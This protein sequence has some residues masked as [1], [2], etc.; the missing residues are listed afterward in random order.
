MFLSVCI[1]YVQTIS[2]WL[3]KMGKNR[4]HYLF[5]TSKM[6]SW[7]TTSSP[8]EAWTRVRIEDMGPSHPDYGLL[9]QKVQMIRA[10]RPDQKWK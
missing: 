7:P 3:L 5:S 4:D 6:S 1:E 2:N 10:P 8:P 9:D